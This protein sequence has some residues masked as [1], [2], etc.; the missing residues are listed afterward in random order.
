M[1]RVLAKRELRAK[2]TDYAV[3]FEVPEFL[4]LGVLYA[5]DGRFAGGAAGL[6]GVRVCRA[7]PIAGRLALTT[8]PVTRTWIGLD[9]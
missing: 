8:R 9:R 1:A 3:Q 6:A 4:M 7:R 5:R 2:E